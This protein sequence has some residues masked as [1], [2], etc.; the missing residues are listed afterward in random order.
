MKRETVVA[1]SVAAAIELLTALGKPAPYGGLWSSSKVA[2]WNWEGI[3]R[4]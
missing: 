4:A 3:G 2:R 1:L